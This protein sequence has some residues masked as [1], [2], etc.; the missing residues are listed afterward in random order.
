MKRAISNL[1]GGFVVGFVGF[2]LFAVAV[3]I[4]IA[5]VFGGGAS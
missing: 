2:F 3:F 1:A 4:G 5:A